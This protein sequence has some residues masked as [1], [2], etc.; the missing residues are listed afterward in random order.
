MS[1]AKPDGIYVSM[2]R[3]EYDRSPRVNHSTLKKFKASP[4]AYRDAQLNPDNEDTPARK[5]GRCSHLATYEPEKYRE[6]VAIWDGD[7]RAGKI[8]EAFRAANEGRE[9]LTADEHERCIALQTAVRSDPIAGPLSRNGK[10]EVT[11]FWTYRE[12][13]IGAVD[14]FEVQCKSRL[15]FITD[16]SLVDL[17]SCRDGSPRT[18]GRQAVNLCYLEQAAFYSDAYFAVTGRRLPYRFIAAESSKPFTVQV[19][20]VPERLI[21]V[22]RENY[23]GWLQ[24]LNLCRLTS[25]WPG[26]ADG[27]LELEVP[28]W[29]VPEDEDDPTGLGIEFPEAAEQGA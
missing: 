8:W 28:E 3:E 7:R 19:Y 11:I 12:P 10:Y 14:G 23:R 22:G 9:L 29:A 5:V 27:E 2:S 16:G 25:S 18:F 20:L 6:D 1:S 15:D 26:Y 24:R 13:G 21:Q 17:K 4:A